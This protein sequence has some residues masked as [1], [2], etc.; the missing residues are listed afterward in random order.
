MTINYT[1][2]K[3]G[4]A[5]QLDGIIAHAFAKA[6]LSPEQNL[7]RLTQQNPK[8]TIV[9]TTVDISDPGV[10][11]TANRLSPFSISFFFPCLP[12]EI[13]RKFEPFRQ[14]KQF[15]WFPGG[16][17]RFAFLEKKKK[18]K[19]GGRERSCSITHGSSRSMIETDVSISE[20]KF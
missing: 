10:H 12:A 3:F 13:R 9:N 16:R 20:A 18:K 19:R 4:R 2:Y 14:F 11:S 1:V 6:D 5:R 17:F 8:F 7:I 15:H